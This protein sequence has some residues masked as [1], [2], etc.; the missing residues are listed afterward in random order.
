M[1]VG[2]AHGRLRA[3]ALDASRER[4][5]FVGKSLQVAPGGPPRTR[6]RRA[7]KRRRR[8]PAAR[9]LGRTPAAG[10]RSRTRHPRPRPAS[11]VTRIAPGICVSSNCDLPAATSTRGA[12]PSRTTGF[13]ATRHSA[14]V[15]RRCRAQCCLRLQALA[16]PPTRRLRFARQARAAELGGQLGTP[17]TGRLSMPVLSH[18]LVVRLDR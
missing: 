9:S 6:H 18:A 10:C 5:N 1:F 13:H 17:A 7:D 12:A 15:R 4:R 11:R 16:A 2:T 3:G 14:V 8:R